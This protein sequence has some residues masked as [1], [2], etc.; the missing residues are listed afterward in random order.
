[1]W[2]RYP[3]PLIP[4]VLDRLRIGRIFSKIFLRGAY[5]LVHF[6]PGGEWKTTFRIH[7]MDISSIKW[8]RSVSPTPRQ[9]SKTWWTIYLGVSWSLRGNLHWRHPSLFYQ[10]GGAHTTRSAGSTQTSGTWTLRQK[11]E[12]WIR[13][14]LYRNPPLRDLTIRDHNGCAQGSDNHRLAYPY[15]VERLVTIIS[16]FCKFLSKIYQWVFTP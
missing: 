14:N 6:K 10:H 9:F 12:M 13:S 16:W 4:T 2:N 7:Y 1:M 15:S 5:N 8:C 3:L 11:G